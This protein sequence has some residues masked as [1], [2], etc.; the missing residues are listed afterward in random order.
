MTSLH[1]YK[2]DPRFKDNASV[3]I[4]SELFAI[5][6][7]RHFLFSE[8]YLDVY[9]PMK[10]QDGNFDQDAALRTTRIRLPVA[11]IVMHYVSGAEISFPVP[12]DTYTIYKLI[13]EHLNDWLN[14]VSTHFITTTP[15][16]EDL[17]KMERLAEALHS[18]ALTY[19]PSK[20]AEGG[21]MFTRLGIGKTTGSLSRVK[22]DI[23]RAAMQGQINTRPGIPVFQ[24]VVDKIYNR[25]NMR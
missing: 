19:D 24:T 6:I 16:I 8:E 18:Y 13:I 4:F 21:N 1:E 20:T 11:G 15:P 3:R 17:R 23:Y 7:P 2:K 9:N 10:D 14:I 25:V 5:D 22:L 12:K